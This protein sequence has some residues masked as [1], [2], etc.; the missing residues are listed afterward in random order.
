PNRV[1]L[2]E[3][4][5]RVPALVSSLSIPPV[6]VLLLNSEHYEQNQ[7]TYQGNTMKRIVLIIFIIVALLSS[8]LVV[9]LYVPTSLPAH[10]DFS[11]LYNTDLALVHRVPIYD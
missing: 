4:P 1:L 9:A 8:M 2:P 3:R 5:A 11:A 10:S 6:Q 7:A